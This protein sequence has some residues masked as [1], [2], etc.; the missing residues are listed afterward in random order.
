MI[1]LGKWK[2]DLETGYVR[3]RSMEKSVNRNME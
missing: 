3:N 2:K 1:C